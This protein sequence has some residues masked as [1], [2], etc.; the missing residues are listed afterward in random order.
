MKPQR[1]N[2]LW[3]CTDQQRFDTIGAL[4]NPHIHTPNL[5]RLVQEG[6][7][8]TR[9]YAQSTV[10]SPSRASFLT[11]RYP[12]TTR[13]TKNGAPYFPQDEVL[14]TKILADHGYDCGLAGK[15]HLSGII[16]RIEPR[17]DDGYRVFK[18]SP[19]QRDAWPIGHD[20]QV[21]LKQQG[22]EWSEHYQG[23][24]G[25]IHE[26]YHQTT[27]ATDEAIN[28]IKYNSQSPWLMS[29]NVYDPHEPFDPPQAYKERYR[30][31]EMPLP[32]WK[33]GELDN[34]PR[35]QQEDYIHGGQG[36]VGPSCASMSDLEKKQYVADYYAMIELVDYNVGRLLD[37][38]ERTGQRDNTVI[39]FMSDHGE[40]LGDHGLILKGAH[41]YEG[42]VHVPLIISWPGH[43]AE[44]R[45]F[46]GLVELVDIAPTLLD[47]AGIEVPYYMQGKSLLPILEGAVGDGYTHKDHVYSEYY[48]ALL[49]SHDNVYATMYYDGRYKL[50]VFHGEEVGELYDHERD[51]DE[52]H[53]LWDDEAYMVKKLELMKKSFDASVF[54]VDPKPPLLLKA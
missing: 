2:I 19:A 17:N 12:R 54:T 10:C 7:A 40:M 46:D 38:L 3:F 24:N 35:I 36:G 45:R 25:G 47:I 18:W 52:F 37:E 48:Y 9:A 11:G 27:W 41:F 49:G 34:K 16:G 6:V 33:D 23:R 5:D 13:V 15:L 28:F 31:E 44:N 43:F 42:L 4:N 51:P 1:P 50:V 22:V 32:K 8:F 53:N 30:A 21:W 29:V 39:V 26:Q 20:Y 14:V